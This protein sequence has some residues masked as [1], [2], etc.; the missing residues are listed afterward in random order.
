MA[1]KPRGPRYTS[2]PSADTEAALY[3]PEQ[4]K[5]E[6]ARRL[7]DARTNLGM[8][9]R[10][11]AD[12]MSKLTRKSIS[13]DAIS[14]YENGQNFPRPHTLAALA[15]VLGIPKEALMPESAIQAINSEP[16]AL[17]MRT[18]I[19]HPDRVFLQINQTMPLS[20]AARILAIIEEFR[21]RETVDRNGS[22]DNRSR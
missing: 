5:K 7:Q 3:D 12:A 4:A 15:K 20:I 17:N 18:A 13:Q 10:E 1:G 16:P 19:G 14:R 11:I 8:S 2:A 6:F 22:G 21:S 9:Q